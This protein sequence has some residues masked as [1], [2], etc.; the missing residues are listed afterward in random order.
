MLLVRLHMDALEHG[1]YRTEREIDEFLVLLRGKAE[2]AHS[3]EDFTKLL[4]DAY[5]RNIARVTKR[6]NPRDSE[7]ARWILSMIRD[8][9]R[10]M[11]TSELRTALALRQHGTIEKSTLAWS[12]IST[13]D[14]Q[15]ISRESSVQRSRHM[16]GCQQRPQRHL[17]P[18]S[19]GS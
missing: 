16:P 9:R 7:K 12:D 6:Q 2:Q 8:A 3:D 4:N 11:T 18:I 5:D 13:R 10:P 14:P 15:N 17:C 19:H 1:S